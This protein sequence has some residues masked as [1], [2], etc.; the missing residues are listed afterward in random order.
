VHFLKSANRAG[1]ASSALLLAAFALGFAPA[2]ADDFGPRGD[3]A[4]VRFSASRLLAHSIRAL[5]IDPSALLIHDAV[6]VNDAAVTSWSSGNRDGILGLIRS[7]G[8]WWAALDYTHGAAGWAADASFPLEPHCAAN[9]SSQPDVAE[10][11]ADGMPAALASAAAAH[12][13]FFRQPKAASR[14]RIMEDRLCGSS[15]GPLLPGGGTLWQMRPYTSGYEITIRYAPSNA[16]AGAS[17][18]PLYARAPTQAEIIPYPA[19]YH[20]LSTAVSYFDLTVNGP[21]PVTFAAGTTVEIWFP[22]ALDDTLK[23]DLTIGFADAPL[24]PIYAKPFDNVLEWRLPAFTA[25]PGRRLMAEVD[26]NWP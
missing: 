11:S 8:R 24:G 7:E 3:V 5:G 21:S 23:Y 18:Q 26:G 2:R 25:M 16:A 17:A 15:S 1:A 6:V 9:S 20:F 10:L 22:F 12:V 19:N 14:P 13:H 4:A